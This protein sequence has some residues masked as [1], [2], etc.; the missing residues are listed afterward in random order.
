[1][2]QDIL[3][4]SPVKRNKEENILFAIYSSLYYSNADRLNEMLSKLGSLDNGISFSTIR[5]LFEY[6]IKFQSYSCLKLLHEKYQDDYEDV[7]PEMKIE[8]AIEKI[9]MSL[10]IIKVEKKHSEEIKKKNKEIQELRE[11]NTRL[12]ERIDNLTLNRDSINDFYQFR[13]EAFFRVNSSQYFLDY[14]IYNYRFFNNVGVF[15]TQ[16]DCYG[17]GK[18]VSSREVYSLGRIRQEN[19]YQFFHF[20]KQKLATP[21][22]H[23]REDL[24]REVDEILR[25]NIDK[26]FAKYEKKLKTRQEKLAR[27]IELLQEFC[28]SYY[29]RFLPDIFPELM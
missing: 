27:K 9:N 17:E 23:N 3:E 10:H 5:E 24:M 13:R 29:N 19:V 6:A 11:E 2:L 25:K 28:H 15:V 1:M 8:D 22:N 4:K 20:H 21:R 12:K 26:I 16:K 7:F 18:E 14:I